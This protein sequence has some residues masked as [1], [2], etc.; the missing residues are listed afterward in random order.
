MQSVRTSN[1][2]IR[3]DKVMATATKSTGLLSQYLE[4]ERCK[5]ECEAHL[6]AMADQRDLPIGHVAM[7]L[8]AVI[9]HE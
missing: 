4:L 9:R 8:A 5:S 3:G 7:E 1:D 6:A 2:I